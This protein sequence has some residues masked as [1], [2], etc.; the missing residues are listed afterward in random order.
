MNAIRTSK[1]KLRKR[2][3]SVLSQLSA[4]ALTDQSC[5]VAKQVV[6]LSAYQRAQHISIYISMDSGELQTR[7]LL[8]D[9][10]ESGKR[11]YVPRCDGTFMD[12]VELQ[13]KED[14]ESLPK[15]RWGIPEPAKDRKGV[16][17]S[18]LDFILV[19]GVAFDTAGNR[20]GHGKGYYDRFLTGN[21][22]L[23]K[24]AVCL[25]EQVVE[26]VPTDEFDKTPDIVLAA[27]GVVFQ[28]KSVNSDTS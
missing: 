9:A 5:R 10:L 20:C 26:T 23:F 24:C 25:N 13:G 17:A 18:A 2:M 11:V 8:Y 3:H 15:N 27:Q 16:D 21:P 4:S 28:S 7:Q 19:P 22:H 6:Q 1:Q 14:L 12:M